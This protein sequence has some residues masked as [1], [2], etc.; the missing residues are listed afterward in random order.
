M[1]G[2]H[3]AVLTITLGN[4]TISGHILLVAIHTNLIYCAVASSGH[5]RDCEEPSSSM[6]SNL[7][8]Y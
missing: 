6:C 8:S 3:T 5:T 4:W 7:L 2:I 1:I